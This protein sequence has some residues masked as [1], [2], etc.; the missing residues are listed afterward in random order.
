MI[1]MLTVAVLV[2][3]LAVS[4]MGCKKE[5][6]APQTQQMPAGHPSME[7]MAPGQGMPGMQG[8]PRVER[9]VI[10]PKDVKA[11]WKSVKLTIEDKK[12]KTS[13]E[14]TVAVGSELA[15]PNTKVKV[16]VLAFLP[17]FMMMDKEI[18]SQSNKPENPA[19]QVAVT[20]GG[21]EVW[22]GWIYSM[23]P[24]IHPLQHDAIDLKLVGGV[25]K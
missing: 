7:G 13:K 3:G 14:Y 4:F 5:E 11:T 12:A 25:S 20:D 18:T 15:V 10:V 9:T 22:K 16:K 23:H 8:A 21:K 2:A 24:G 1:K 6:R 19:A 17:H